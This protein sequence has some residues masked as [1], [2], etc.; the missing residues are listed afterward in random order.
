MLGALETEITAIWFKLGLQA[1]GLFCDF[2]G[3][4]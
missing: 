3:G 4:V 2:V 1:G